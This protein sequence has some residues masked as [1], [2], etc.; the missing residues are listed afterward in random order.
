[1]AVE[2]AFEKFDFKIFNCPTNLR[3]PALFRVDPGV[4]DHQVDPAPEGQGLVKGRLE[5]GL[6]G[7]VHP[8]VPR[9]LAELSRRRLALLQEFQLC[10][11]FSLRS[12]IW[13]FKSYVD[14]MLVEF[15]DDQFKN[16]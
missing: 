13:Q 3:L 11:H 12:H 16:C 4:V 7:H 9:V 14:Y 15:K 5:A 8:V 1:M 2:R 10:G 6:A